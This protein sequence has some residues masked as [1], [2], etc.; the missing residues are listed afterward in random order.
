MI[1]AEPKI[2][3]FLS[4][5]GVIERGDNVENWHVLIK[6]THIRLEV[7]FFFKNKK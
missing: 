6:K 4:K 3:N 2:P 5:I 1:V 7:H